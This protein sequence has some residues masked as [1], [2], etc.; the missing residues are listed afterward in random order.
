MSFRNEDRTE[1]ITETLMHTKIKKKNLN[2]TS[3]QWIQVNGIA[4]PKSYLWELHF[5][6]YLLEIKIYALIMKSH[7]DQ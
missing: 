2:H 6:F 4:L 3:T 7:D 1:Q 5:G